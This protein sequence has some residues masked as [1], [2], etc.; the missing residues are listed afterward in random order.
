MRQTKQVA[1][2]P[3]REPLHTPSWMLQALT[4]LMSANAFRIPKKCNFIH[5]LLRACPTPPRVS[6]IGNFVNA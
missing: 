6:G 1:S 5:V 3:T 2:A 4:C